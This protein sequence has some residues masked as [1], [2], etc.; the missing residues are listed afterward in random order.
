MEATSTFQ[1]TTTRN[2]LTITK[3]EFLEHLERMKRH[4]NHDIRTAQST[5]K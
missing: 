1:E 5:L 3:Q 2:K 4:L